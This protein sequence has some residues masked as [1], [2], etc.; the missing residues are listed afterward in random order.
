MYIASLQVDGYK[1]NHC[2]HNV[3]LYLE[4]IMILHF[5]MVLT[6]YNSYDEGNFYIGICL[7]C[8][9]YVDVD[10]SPKIC[11]WR[12]LAFPLSSSIKLF[13]INIFI[14]SAHGSLPALGY[15]LAWFIAEL[16]PHSLAL[17]IF[18]YS[19]DVLPLSFRNGI[20]KDMLIHIKM[21][22][23]S[24]SDREWGGGFQD[25]FNVIFNQAQLESKPAT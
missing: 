8:R 5:A 17:M 19:L 6:I 25:K 14:G 21:S 12:I 11:P 10:P 13:F 22:T 15:T 20:H 9:E 7:A 18:P 1:R 2:L 4:N 16:K 3:C 23:D 24:S